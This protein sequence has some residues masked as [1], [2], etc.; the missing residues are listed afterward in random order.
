MRV[1]IVI[2]M[3]NRL[4]MTQ[5]CLR[6]LR[7]LTRLPEQVIVVDNG[8]WPDP[9]AALEALYP[10]MVVLRLDRNHGFAGGCN[11]GIRRALVDGADAIMLL[12]N[13]AT[14]DPALLGELLRGLGEDD[15]IAAVGAKTLTDESPPRIHGAYGVLTFH[16]S[17]VRVE[18]WLEAQIEQFSDERDVD[19]VS[20]GAALLRRG[21]LE[22]VGLFDEEFFAYHEDVDWCTRARQ[23]GWRIRYVPRAVVYHRMHASTG[24]GYVSPITY[25]IARNSVLFV[26]KNATARQ[27]LTFAV[28]TAGNLLKE[29]LY[30]WRMGELAGYRLRLRGLRDG[31]LRRP[32]PLAELGLVGPQYAE[33]SP[34]AA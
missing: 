11:A 5:R 19:S 7:G 27:A 15:R 2:P 22:A 1:A 20:G 30:R 14:A 10:G 3:W 23:R 17:L 24:G 16:G 32:V 29:A 12:N 31:L 34:V 26:R 21:A 9:R 8:S 4:E 18:G 28:Y 25:L 13:D 33:A 6:S